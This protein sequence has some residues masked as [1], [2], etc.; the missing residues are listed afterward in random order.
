MKILVATISQYIVVRTNIKSGHIG[1]FN[2]GTPWGKYIGMVY[3]DFFLRLGPLL[4]HNLSQ[5][6]P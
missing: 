4:G 3:W 5:D 2:Q 1:I 6:M